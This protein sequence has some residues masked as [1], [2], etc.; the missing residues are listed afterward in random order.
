M[1]FDFIIECTSYCLKM[2]TWL[3]HIINMFFKIA[4]KQCEFQSIVNFSFSV[5]IQLNLFNW[6]VKLFYTLDWKGA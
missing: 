5:I 3:H 1:M 6:Y 2:Q 4:Q